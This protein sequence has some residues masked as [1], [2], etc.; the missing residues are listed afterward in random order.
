[1]TTEESIQKSENEVDNVLSDRVSMIVLTGEETEEI[2][3][4]VTDD[5]FQRFVHPSLT[6]KTP[7]RLTRLP[8]EHV[9]RKGSS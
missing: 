5:S 1:M 4:H 8:F 6:H 9:Q 7:I 2:H 3:K